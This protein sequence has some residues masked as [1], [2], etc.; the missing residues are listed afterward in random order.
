MTKSPLTSLGAHE[1]RKYVRVRIYAVT[2]Y[3]CQARN[4]VVGVQTQISDISE[5][6]AMLLTFM[7]GIPMNTIVK[8]DFVMPGK[9]DLLISIEGQV[10]HTGF[11]E[12]DLY[13]SG[14]EFLKIKE[15]DRLA[16]RDFVK[17]HNK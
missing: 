5:G 1:R 11:L 6:G 7:E 13:R 17:N 16:I 9:K 12:K 14:V 4:A 15:T 8:M 2:R 10:R 3:F